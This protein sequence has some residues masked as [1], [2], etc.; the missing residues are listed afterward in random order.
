MSATITVSVST[1]QTVDIETDADVDIDDIVNELSD[2]DAQRIADKL[3]ARTKPQPGDPRMESLYLALCDGNHTR[4][5]EV[6][7]DILW[8]YGGRI[9]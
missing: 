8:A 5:I 6:A 7:R 4:I 2:D 3:A 1:R 9:A